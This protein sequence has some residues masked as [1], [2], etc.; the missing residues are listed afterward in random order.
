MPD[1]CSVVLLFILHKIAF[2]NSFSN[3]HS[4]ILLSIDEQRQQQP[5]RFQIRPD[6]KRIKNVKIAMAMSII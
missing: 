4:N 5:S 3:N 6:E 1:G 2:S